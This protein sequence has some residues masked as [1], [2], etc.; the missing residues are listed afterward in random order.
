MLPIVRVALV[1][2]SVHSKKN[3]T[4]TQVGT[5]DWGIAEIGLTTVVFVF[6]LR[7]VDFG[8]LESSGML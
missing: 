6:V 3:I 4:K 7:N 2:V 5:R 8:S 1:I